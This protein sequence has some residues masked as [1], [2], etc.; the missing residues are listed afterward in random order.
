M[1]IWS[2]GPSILSARR[3]WPLFWPVTKASESVTRRRDKPADR[4]PSAR[5][6]VISTLRRRFGLTNAQ[7]RLYVCDSR[8]C[9]SLK[10]ADVLGIRYDYSPVH[11]NVTDLS[12]S[13]RGDSL[14]PH[15]LVLRQSQNQSSTR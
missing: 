10:E 13:R 6:S 4:V 8:K 1:D 11:I 12:A 2:R 9:G 7:G 14:D 3:R 15:C 5:P